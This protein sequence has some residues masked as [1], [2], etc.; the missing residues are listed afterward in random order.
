MSD[1][2]TEDDFKGQYPWRFISL[3]SR[4][5]QISDILEKLE[6]LEEET[7]PALGEVSADCKDHKALDALLTAGEL[8]Q[9][10][11][12]WALEHASGSA[13]AGLTFA[14]DPP[15]GYEEDDAYT[16]QL[17]A[18][19]SHR[20]EALGGMYRNPEALDP[21]AARAMLFSLVE[22]NSG[23]GPN[24]IQQ[25]LLEAL[26]RLRFGEVHH[27]LKPQKSRRKVTF[28]EVKHQL[29]ALTFI[30]Y[31]VGRGIAKFK[32]QEEVAAAYNVG[33]HTL[34]TWER[35][36]PGDLGRWQVLRALSAAKRAGQDAKN[37]VADAD[38]CSALSLGEQ[39]YGAE[40]LRLKADQY[41]AVRRSDS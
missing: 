13:F 32:A 24:S 12:G 9:N 37:E 2:D 5:E 19:N 28:E 4:I 11:A 22:A 35:R 1:A 3:K 33:P 34:R 21:E 14:S 25:M 20:H 7:N 38:G 15:E 10:V 26:A 39:R 31:R 16:S 36:V 29:T 18:V 27:L 23:G 17:A 40:A 8:V 6:Q 41:K 30:N